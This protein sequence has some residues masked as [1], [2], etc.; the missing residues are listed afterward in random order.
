MNEGSPGGAAISADRNSVSLEILL[1]K[2]AAVLGWP[3]AK[4]SRCASVPAD[5]VQEG[6]GSRNKRSCA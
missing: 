4:E 2:K 6:S 3:A 5:Q 1:G